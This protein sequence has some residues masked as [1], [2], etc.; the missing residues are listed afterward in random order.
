MSSTYWQKVAVEGVYV[1]CCQRFTVSAMR[2]RDA[3]YIAIGRLLGELRAALERAASYESSLDGLECGL[4]ASALTELFGGDRTVRDCSRLGP[5]GTTLHLARMTLMWDRPAFP[6]ARRA[7]GAAELLC[8]SYPVAGTNARYANGHSLLVALER[9]IRQHAAVLHA[10]D[11]LLTKQDAY[12]LVVS[13]FKGE[14]AQLHVGTTIPTDHAG[15]HDLPAQGYDRRLSIPRASATAGRASNFSFL[16]ASAPEPRPTEIAVTMHPGFIE[17]RG[18]GA[19]ADLS[20]AEGREWLERQLRI[21]DERERL[22]RG[23]GAFPSSR[24]LAPA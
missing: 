16:H 19:L 11:A 2:G 23:R 18:H 14:P 3:E 17:Q 9:A 21:A 5:L 13:W 22:A 20:S 8:A 7:Q 1:G 4:L 15:V 6:S 24:P 12:A 10:G